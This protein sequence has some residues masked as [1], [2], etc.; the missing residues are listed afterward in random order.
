MAYGTVALVI[1]NSGICF[2]GQGIINKVRP[3]D[4]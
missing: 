3:N 4:K 2:V 1:F